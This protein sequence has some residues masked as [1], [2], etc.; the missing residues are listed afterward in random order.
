M[1]EEYKVG[2]LKNKGV[3]IVYNG[4]KYD[5][6]YDSYMGDYRFTKNGQVLRGAYGRYT[7]LTSRGDREYYSQAFKEGFISERVF[8]YCKDYGFKLLYKR[9]GNKYVTNNGVPSGGFKNCETAFF[10][11]NRYWYV[12]IGPD[13]Y[14]ET[15]KNFATLADLLDYVHVLKTGKKSYRSL[16]DKAVDSCIITG[17]VGLAAYAIYRK[18]TDKDKES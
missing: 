18:M 10:D 12:K 16:F 8:E 3:T 6:W 4:Q 13:G 7:G 2:P 14:P 9:D 5:V 15:E 11:R 17:A 1:R